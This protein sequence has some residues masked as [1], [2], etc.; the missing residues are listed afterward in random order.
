MRLRSE[1]RHASD[2]AK[3]R[4]RKVIIETW[5]Q[6]SRYLADD[7]KVVGRM[8]STRRLCSC[9]ICKC[10]ICQS[11]KAEKEAWDVKEAS[12][13]VYERTSLEAWGASS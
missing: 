8:A 13:E 5:G 3:Q 11:F 7:P 1:R 6:R 2:R 12:E 10:G 9:P 4:A